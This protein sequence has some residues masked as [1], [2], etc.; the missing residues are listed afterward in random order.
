[1]LDD[2]NFEYIEIDP[3]DYPYSRYRKLRWIK[4]NEG[5]YFTETYEVLD[6]PKTN[7]DKF[8]EVKAGE[9]NRLDLIA[10]K[11]YKNPSLWWVIAEA[12][13][14]LDPSKVEVGSM[15]RV[16]PREVIFGYGGVLA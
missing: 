1:M 2:N 11:Y 16:P 5:T 3:T 7:K 13:D 14:I 15:L 6:I 9:E 8:H 12:N 10:Y 4:D